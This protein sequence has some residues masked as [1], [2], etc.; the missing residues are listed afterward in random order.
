MI[1]NEFQFGLALRNSGLVDIYWNFTLT[2][3]PEGK[4]PSFNNL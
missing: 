4:T 3:T 1:S 2:Q